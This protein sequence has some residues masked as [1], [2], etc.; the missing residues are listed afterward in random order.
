MMRYK[1]RTDVVDV[2]KHYGQVKC[3]YKNATNRDYS[4]H[5]EM[6][7]GTDLKNFER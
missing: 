2:I 1:F 3:D 6:L 7:I 4:L 5:V